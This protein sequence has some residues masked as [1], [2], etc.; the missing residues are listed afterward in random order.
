MMFKPFAP[1]KFRQRIFSQ[2]WML[3]LQF[4]LGMMLNLIGSEAVGVKHTMYLVILVLHILNA[5]GLVEGA[6][7][8]ALKQ[9]SRLAWWAAITVSIAS[10]G[11]VLTMLTTQDI[12]SFIMACGFLISAWL[13]VALYIRADRT[14]RSR[15]RQ[16]E[17][18]TST[19]QRIR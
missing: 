19:L 18:R 6:I 3:A 1:R 13:Y 14:F 9:R 5:L 15:D 8:V 7:Y 17:P 4:M 16:A 10:C 2:L 12:W 11:G